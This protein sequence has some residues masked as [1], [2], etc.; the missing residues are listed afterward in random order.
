LLI[1][2]LGRGHAWTVVP[3]SVSQVLTAL[4]TIAKQLPSD[5]EQDQL[6]E[7]VSGANAVL[8]PRNQF[9]HGVWLP[10]FRR[11]AAVV[12][13]RPGRE[14]LQGRFVTTE[15]LEELVT[16]VHKLVSVVHGLVPPPPTSS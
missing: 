15:D 2:R 6:K 12:R 1:H 10:V 9:A 11:G 16:E 7:V 13:H 8:E 3:M 4:S 5:G 14:A